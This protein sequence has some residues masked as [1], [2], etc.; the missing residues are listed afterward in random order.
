MT[1]ARMDKRKNRKQQ[2]QGMWYFLSNFLKVSLCL[3]AI[4]SVVFFIS[5][6]HLSQKF[7]I[8]TVRVYGV[9][10]VKEEDIKTTLIPLVNKGFFATNVDLI[11]DRILLQPWAADVL[12]Q[13]QWPDQVDVTVVERKAVAH[14]STDALLSDAG[15]LFTPKTSKLANANLPIFIGPD[16]Q[17]IMML[18]YFNEMNRLL[19]PIHAKI[20][21]LELTPYLSWK[22][23]LDNGVGIQIGHADVLKRLAQMVAVYPKVIGDYAK[24]VESIDLRYSNGVAVKWKAPVRT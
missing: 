18:N 1:Y 7:P 24:D 19:K 3:S 8:K 11:R 17:H 20:S 10:N 12:V 23:R 6:F 21:Y 4:L 15:V 13:R 14:W 2:P 9:Q 22:M 16:G 5:H